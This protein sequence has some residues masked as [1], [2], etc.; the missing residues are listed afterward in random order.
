MAQAPTA[1]REAP[2]RAARRRARRGGPSDL[3][4]LK[5]LEPGDA[6]GAWRACGPRPR[7]LIPG[8]FPRGWFRIRLKMT[9]ATPGRL[10]L[11]AGDGDGTCLRRVETHGTVNLDVFDFISSPA[12]AFSLDPLGGPGEFRLELLRIEPLSASRALGHAV[13]AKLRLLRKYWQTGPALRRGLGMLARAEFRRLWRKLFQGLDGPNLRGGEPYD[14]GQAYDAWRRSRA[15]TDADRD[16]LRREAAAL[17][18]PPIFSV[19]L[20]AGGGDADVRRSMESV[21]RQTYPA[22]QQCIT[23]DDSAALSEY[24]Q[25]DNRILLVCAP[26]ASGAAAALNAA[27]AAASGEYIAVLDAGDELAEHALSRLARAVVG[28]R[29]LDMLYADEDRATPDGRHVEPFFKPDWSP[30]LLLSWMY[31]GRPSFYRT[32]LVRQLGGFRPEFDAAHEYD[33]AL[34]VASATARV[35]HVP[36]VLY[37]RRTPADPADGEAA[38]AALRDHL[39]QTG[40]EGVV[41]PG[42]RPGLHR[43]RFTLRGAPTVS[44]IIPSA[45][46][47]VRVRGERTFYLLK[48]LESIAKSSW[49]NYEV[50]VLHGRVV[51]AALGEQLDRWGAVRAAYAL[52][53]SWARAMN[54]GAVLARG[55]HLL[56]LN[57]DVEVI[58]P[59]WLERLLEYSQQPEVGAVGAKLFFPGGRLQHAGVTVL[60]GRPAHAFYGCRGEHAGYFNSLLVPRNCSAVTG[61]CLMT[62]AEVFRSAGGFDEAFP[63]N[64]NDVDYCLRLVAGG[65]RV[66]WTPHARLYHHELGT[67]PAGVRPAERDAFLRRWGAAWAV[68]PF[69]NPNLSTDHLD[70]RIRSAAASIR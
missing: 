19:L 65:R 17:A 48:C 63:L 51:P 32:A 45:C 61:A 40:R 23:G 12:H 55:A 35:G 22:W 56:F 7:F 28:D 46:R 58:N 37:H 41:E 21:L 24:A 18:D 36:D 49:R 50:I 66:V 27:L 68:D 6:S 26:G 11:Y 69:H 29:G 15:L 57:D 34:R 14:E 4:P 54:Q 30:E 67:R 16:R 43:V 10:T 5:D 64:Y 62:R 3:V 70:C 1:V 31:T 38:R 2:P 52:P 20:R 44:I 25:R 60:A 39:E 33:L 53:F 42:S 47:P 13:V 9:S 8:P 59:D